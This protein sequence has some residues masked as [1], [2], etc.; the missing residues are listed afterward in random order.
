M[1]RPER[2]EISGNEDQRYVTADDHD[3][4]KRW[5]EKQARAHDKRWTKQDKRENLRKLSRLIG[6]LDTKDN[7]K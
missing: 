7:R 5:F 2:K 6:G 1:S 3:A 4:A